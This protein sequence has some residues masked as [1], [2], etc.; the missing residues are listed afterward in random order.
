MDSFATNPSSKFEPFSIALSN[1]PTLTGL[2]FNPFKT[3][4][5]T[6]SSKPL[7]VGIH[8]VTCSAHIFDLTPESSVANLAEALDMPFLAFNRPNYLASSGWLVNRSNDKLFPPTDGLTYFE[9]DG[10]WLHDYI[11]PA[12]QS[13]FLAPNNF[14]SIITLS[15]SMAVPSTIIAASHYSSSSIPPPYKWAGACLYGY[16]ETPTQIVQS[17]QQRSAALGDSLPI[18]FNFDPAIHIPPF[19][20]N[21]RI[22]LMAG[23]AQVHSKDIED[24][25]LRQQTPF[26][27][28]EIANMMGEWAAQKGRYTA[29]V[30]IPVLY[31][32]GEY[33]YIWVGDRP[34]VDAFCEG[35]VNAERVEGALIRGAPHAI[36]L[37]AGGVGDAWMRRVFAWGVEVAAGEERKGLGV[38]RYV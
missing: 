20:P 30:K 14:S 8:G 18:P 37:A 32:L 17:C 6:G 36:E 10:H 4:S 22:E 15:H 33:D 25:L 35:F 23:P 38:E 3:R 21:D 34:N 16:S 27:L 19:T 1:G 7:V 13:H 31:A 5:P 28:G 2:F 11:F 12:L 9:E 24:A 26:H 29:G